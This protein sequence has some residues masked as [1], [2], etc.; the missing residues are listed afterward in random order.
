MAAEAAPLVSR[1]SV[2]GGWWKKERGPIP[3]ARGRPTLAAN[4][5]SLEA[6]Y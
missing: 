4:N 1:E 6:N 3:R 5:L 2:Q